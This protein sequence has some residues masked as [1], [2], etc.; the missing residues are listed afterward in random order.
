[1]VSI[2]PS[3]ST[4]ASSGA[5]ATV[6]LVGTVQE[7]VEAGCVVLVDDQ[8]AVLANLLGRRAATYQF[9]S[10]VTVTG[11][12]AEDVMSICQQGKPFM[13]ADLAVS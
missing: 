4:G 7:G 12:F 8:G 11:R 9:G 13:V 10:K 6:Q 3:Q 1:M 5:G 2:P